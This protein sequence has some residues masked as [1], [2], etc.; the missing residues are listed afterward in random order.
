M[1]NLIKELKKLA[2]DYELSENFSW[3]LPVNCPLDFPEGMSDQ[4][5]KNIYLK[6]ELSSS[7]LGEN[8]LQNRYWVI[9]DWGGIRSL[10]KNERNDGL[11]QKLDAELERGTLTK[12]VF[13]IISSLSKVASFLDYKKYAIYDS[14][15]IYSLNW[16]LFKHT[17]V[18]ELFPQPSGRNADLSK[19]ELNT[20][21]NLSDKSIVYRSHKV[22]YHE[23]CELLKELSLEVYGKPEPYLV[24]LLL[25]TVAPKYIV[26]DVAG[27]LTISVN[28]A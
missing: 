3:E 27:S 19:Y 8:A 7:L 21:F 15:V 16:L 28:R 17:E 24:E 11:I 18:T 20:I 10:K 22:A 23:Y 25:F 1:K 5:E 9:Q 2:R 13:S 14:R 26:S 12:P 6:H 4:Y